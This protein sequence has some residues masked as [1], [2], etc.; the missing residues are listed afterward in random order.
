MIFV[1]L[2]D[3]QDFEAVADY[4]GGEPFE[5]HRGYAVHEFTRDR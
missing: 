1:D 3:R 4:N 2:L 5:D